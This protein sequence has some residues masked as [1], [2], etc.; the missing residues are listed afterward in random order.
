MQPFVRALAHAM[1]LARAPA[2]AQVLCLLYHGKESPE[3]PFNVAVRLLLSCCPCCFSCCHLLLLQ[4]KLAEQ[5]DI[6]IEA[7]ARAEQLEED[8]AGLR[9]EVAQ[10]SQG[11]RV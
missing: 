5:A 10:V 2:L 6:A 11:L 4:V 8:L 1:H 9:A 7:T 3:F